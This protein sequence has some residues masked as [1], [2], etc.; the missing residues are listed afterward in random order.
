MHYVANSLMIEAE[1]R[2]CAMVVSLQV[3]YLNKMLSSID[4]LDTTQLLVKPWTRTNAK[5]NNGASILKT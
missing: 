4:L 5:V 1:I 2:T 3:Q